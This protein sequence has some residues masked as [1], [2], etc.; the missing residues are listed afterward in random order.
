MKFFSKSTKDEKMT[1]YAKYGVEIDG[2]LA[3]IAQHE[4]DTKTHSDAAVA[5][6]AKRL[7]A[8]DRLRAK[9]AELQLA[10]AGI[11]DFIAGLTQLPPLVLS[12]DAAQQAAEAEAARIAAEQEAEAQRAADAEAARIAAEAEAAALAAEEEA[13]A[14]QAEADR[15]AAEQA[16]AEAAAAEGTDVET[17][18]DAAPAPTT[19]EGTPVEE[20][21]PEPVVVP[22][23]EETAPDLLA[24]DDTPEPPVADPL[25][26]FGSPQI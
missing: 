19:F 13:A 17:P 5:A 2:I 16:A 25:T 11:G 4:A 26:G 15:L 1:D 6:H 23:V 21:S 12:V 9:Q 10:L 3:E 20:P 7:E 14:A 22:T 18:V 8:E 24:E